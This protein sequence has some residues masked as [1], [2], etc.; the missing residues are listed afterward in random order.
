MIEARAGV[1]N[2]LNER[3]DDVPGLRAPGRRFTV[4]MGCSR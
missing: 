4:E 1:E 3:Y 2:I